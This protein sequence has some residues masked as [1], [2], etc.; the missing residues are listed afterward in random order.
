MT[1]EEADKLCAIIRTADGGC[2]VCVA[3]LCHAINEASFGF[4]FHIDGHI[5]VICVPSW[6]G[7][8]EDADTRR[9]P[10]VAAVAESQIGKLKTE[11]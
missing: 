8:P 1:Q 9:Y 6:S 11:E 4:T 10:N 2:S 5:E 7:D 3:S